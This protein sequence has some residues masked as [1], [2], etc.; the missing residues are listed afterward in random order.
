MKSGVV[1]YWNDGINAGMLKI[2][3]EYWNIGVME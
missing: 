3:L 1:E 2:M